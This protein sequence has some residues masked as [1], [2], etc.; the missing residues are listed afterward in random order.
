MAIRF[1]IYIKHHVRFFWQVIEWLNAVLFETLYGNRFKRCLTDV[2]SQYTIP[3]ITFRKLLF[4][5]IDCLYSLICTQGESRLAYFK[6]HEFDQTS[7]R[8][9]FKNPAFIMMGAFEGQKMVGYFFLRCFCNKKCFVG[10][11]IDEPYEGKGIGRVMNDIMYH[12]GWAATFRVLSTISKNNKWV[13]R[14]HKNNSTLKVLKELDNNFLLVKFI[15]P[16][17]SR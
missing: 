1:L 5:D 4:S 12:V 15:N 7:L 16:N 9:A 13:M 6:P 3:G 14:S 17:A 11:L 8:K 10:R 2:F